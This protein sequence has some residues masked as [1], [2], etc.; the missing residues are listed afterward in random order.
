MGHEDLTIKELLEKYPDG[1]SIAPTGAIQKTVFASSHFAA[2]ARNFPI[3]PANGG[4]LVVE[5][6]DQ[7]AEIKRER[8]Q[9]NVK[10]ILAHLKGN[11]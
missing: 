10:E 9:Q 6:I 2:V 4:Y 5:L 7:D 8:T 1:F 11:K 3:A